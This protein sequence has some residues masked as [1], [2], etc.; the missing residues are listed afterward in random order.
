MNLETILR[1][2]MALGVVLALILV[3]AWA[4]RRSGFAGIAVKPAGRRR[5]LGVVEALSLGPK[6][7]LV[8]IRCDGSEHLLLLG[9]AGDSVVERNLPAVE[10]FALPPQGESA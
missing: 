4:A 7:R 3:L 2:T 5:R 10:G 6:H 8:I 1:F 9:A